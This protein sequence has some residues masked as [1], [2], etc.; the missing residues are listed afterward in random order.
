MKPAVVLSLAVLLFTGCHKRHGGQRSEF[1]LTISEPITIDPTFASD[2]SG[3]VICQNLFEG[4]LNNPPDNGPMRPGVA[5]RYEVTDQGRKYTFFLRH[6]AVWSNGSP[7][8]TADFIY[9]Y[10]RLLDPASGARGT[11]LF[12]IIKGAKAYSNGSLKAFSGVGIHAEGPYKLVF[13]LRAP[14]PYFLRLLGYASFAPIPRHVV[15]KWG[16]DWIRPGHI[17]S[18]GPYSLVSYNPD[19]SMVLLKNSR[20]WNQRSVRINRAVFY[21]IRDSEIAYQWFRAG[22]I[23]WMKGSLSASMIRQLRSQKDPQLHIDP[24]LCTY[25][26][27]PNLEHGPLADHELRQAISMAID[28]QGFGELFGG[29]QEGATHFVPTVISRVNGYVPPG[30][31]A[32]FDPK[33]ARQL[34]DDFLRRSNNKIPEIVLLFNAEGANKMAAQYVAGQ[35]RENLN[36]KIRLEVADWK[37]LISRI[38]H[39][40]FVLA[41]ASWCADYPDPLNFLSILMT[42]SPNNYPGYNNPAY[43]KLLDK[44]ILE[45]DQQKRNRI[46]QK[47]ETMM[48]NDVA[49]IPLF[50]YNRIYMLSSKVKGFMPNIMDRHPIQYLHY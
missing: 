5:A 12:Y 43:D 27:V 39:R 28:R 23:Q 46:F 38:E 14:A 21:F 7:V 34:Y 30:S 31:I 24:Y 44:A 47:A 33:K 35:L 2:E 4:L 19:D 18:N 49:V 17:V 42:G 37:S 6:N 45:P 9:A 40:N 41:R 3:A 22:K 29:S 11:E 13:N 36:L 16:K 26:L 48:L 10:K 1:A 32:R 15:K 25:Y 8:T 20:Y 50:F